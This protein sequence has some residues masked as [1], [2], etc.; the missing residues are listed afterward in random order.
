MAKKGMVADASKTAFSLETPSYREPSSS[1]IPE[2]Q[3]CR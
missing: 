1:P 3:E 2:V